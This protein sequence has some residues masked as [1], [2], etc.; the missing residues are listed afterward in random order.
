MR[1]FLIAVFVLFVPTWCVRAGDE[2]EDAVNL[3]RIPAAK[4]EETTALENERPGLKPLTDGG[5]ATVA[6]A[7]A[8]FDVTYS[9][10]GATVWP[11]K[12][13]VRL[14]SP[15]P[16]EAGAGEIELWASTVS[17]HAGW[18][19]LKS[20][21]L[22]AKGDAQ[23][24]PFLPSG[25]K[26]LMVR[27]LPAGDAK[28]IAVAQV[29]V[30]GHE[31]PPA[32]HY[33][34]KESPTQAI[35]VLERLNR[36]SALDPK[37]TDDE[38]AVFADV[39]DGRFQKR[40]FD[41]AV[42]LASGVTDGAKRQAYMKQLD[43]LAEQAAKA[44]AD[45]KTPKEKSEKLLKW[46]HGG[47][48][49]KGYES[50]QTS[51]SAILDTGKFNCVSSAAL[52]NIFALRQGLDVRGIEV[53]DHALSILYDGTKH[54]DV[55]TTTVAGFNPVRDPEA[56]KR[57][58]EK[59][60]V[61]LAESHPDQRREVR[62]AG[63]AAIIYYNRGVELTNGK[64]YHEALLMYFRAMS[65]DPEF[66]SAVK[67]ALAVLVNWSG[68]LAKEKKFEEA[69]EV[70]TVGVDLDP[71]DT[72]LQHNRKVTWC[73][74][75]DSQSDADE[76]LA[77][78]RRGAKEVPSEKAYFRAHESWIFL[79]A[80]E[81]C[82]EKE[83]WEAA[84]KIVEPGL[85][86]LED[87]Q[88]EEIRNWQRDVRLR[89]A[90]AEE[91]K[92]DFQK[93]VEVLAAGMDQYPKDDRFANNIAYCV[94]EWAR[95]VYGKGGKENEDRAKA[96]LKTQTKR[97]EKLS[98]MKGLSK[99]HVFWVADNLRKDNKPDEALAA[100]LRHA[101]LLE[102]DNDAKDVIQSLVSNR[103]MAL[104]MDGKWREAVTVC[105]EALMKWPDDKEFKNILFFM[106]QQGAR[107]L[108]GEGGAENEKKT[109]EF[110]AWLK[111]NFKQPEVNHIVR[112]QVRDAG[113]MLA[114]K[115][116]FEGSLDLVERHKDVLSGNDDVT[117]LSRHFYD[118]WANHYKNDKKWQAAV[119]VYDKGL[120]RFPKDKHLTQNAVA[121]W[122]QWA[123]SFSKPEE[124]DQKI[125][126]YTDAL[127]HFPDDKDLKTNLEIYKKQKK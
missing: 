90:Q 53:P 99:S 18:Q 14:P 69:L 103:A 39:K 21:S 100:V 41:E 22:Q 97:F 96:V 98:A 78:L 29:A 33:T 88:R 119:D 20:T 42:L 52:F 31:R 55:E 91:K 12:L 36:L 117:E 113:D 123:E 70:L 75:A 121:T 48:M 46:L 7:T 95:S 116:M 89:W 1:R 60:G 4:L 111:E 120:K 30:Y 9:F 3:L 27:F 23:V 43:E 38:A 77:I 122:Y 61:Y 106:M 86:K 126:V 71:K 28:H 81:A 49:S 26:W 127:K 79:R 17:P 10:G 118:Q 63:L 32:Q 87:Q 67:N 93:A 110:L 15:L 11:E 72:A 65:L 85:T 114:N 83:E 125:Q 101:D 25:A 54:A 24:F 73:E 107:D 80:G 13:E 19:L 104:G 57:F 102:D 68:E 51:V 34:F 62:E 35:K 108:Y 2:S 16:K 50:H 92:G 82:I 6:V 40:S 94:Q 64:R 76:A 56:A 84:M 8:P 109:K 47:P 37:I 44:T 5:P 59:T 124:L 105:H 45:A 112:R 58:K 115:E 66:D 74:W